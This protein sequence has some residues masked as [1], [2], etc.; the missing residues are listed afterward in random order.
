MSDRSDNILLIDREIFIPCVPASVISEIYT[1]SVELILNRNRWRNN[2]SPMPFR[3]AIICNSSHFHLKRQ[4]LRCRRRTAR[5]AG[6]T[7]AKGKKHRSDAGFTH[8]SDNVC[9][10]EDSNFPSR[11]QSRPLVAS[12]G[13]MDAIRGLVDLLASMDTNWLR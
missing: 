3:L 2:C 12:R 9:V 10:D 1:V 8:L 7:C 11:L 6:D 4:V 5:D 13:K